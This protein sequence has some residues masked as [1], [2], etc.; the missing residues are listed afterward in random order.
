MSDEVLRAAEESDMATH[1]AGA[2]DGLRETV[3]RL[4]GFQRP[5]IVIRGGTVD[6]VMERILAIAA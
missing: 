1:V 4:D 5:W 2:V 6:S 3:E